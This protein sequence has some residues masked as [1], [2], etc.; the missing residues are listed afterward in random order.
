MKRILLLILAF[1]LVFCGCEKKDPLEYARQ[2]RSN[3]TVEAPPKLTTKDPKEIALLSIIHLDIEKNY[4]YLYD[5][6][7]E[8]FDMYDKLGGLKSGYSEDWYYAF[9]EVWEKHMGEI[10][11][12]NDDYMGGRCF[13]IIDGHIKCSERTRD[14]ARYLNVC[15]EEIENADQLLSEL[16]SSMAEFGGNTKYKDYIGEIIISAKDSLEEIRQR[17][18][19]TKDIRNWIYED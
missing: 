11:D 12:D 15:Y 4:D 18:N 2:Y 5:Q 13:D 17:M 7:R 19:K 8:I 3:I 1:L 14:Y 10:Y 6:Y 16:A 9:Y